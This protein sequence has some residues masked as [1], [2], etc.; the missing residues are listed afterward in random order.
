MTKVFKELFHPTN[1]NYCMNLKKKLRENMVSLYER[2]ISFWKKVLDHNLHFHLGHFRKHDIS[3]EHSMLNAINDLVMLIP[4]KTIKRVLDVGCGWGGAAFELA[5][6]W[7]SEVI[8]LTISKRQTHY[9]NKLAK[10]GH[11]PVQAKTVDIENYKFDTVGVFDV[12][13]LYE[14]LEH[15]VDR[16]SLLLNLQSASCINTHLAIAMSCRSSDVNRE[17]TCSDM[18]GVQPLESLSELMDM[19]S[20]SGWHVIAMEDH[21]ELTLNVWEL[22]VNNLKRINQQGYIELAEKLIA[23]FNELEYLYRIGVLRSVQIVAQR[24]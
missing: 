5:N 3:L 11:L 16:T 24:R 6:R 23:E 8:G 2:P 15:I 10:V 18:L 13:W 4:P 14:S 12:I 22:W 9:I 1:D 17:E 7:N 21:T 20:E 19:L